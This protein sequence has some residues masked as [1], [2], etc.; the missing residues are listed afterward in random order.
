MFWSLY[1]LILVACAPPRARSVSGSPATIRDLSFW[2]ATAAKRR[3]SAWAVRMSG[4]VAATNAFAVRRLPMSDRDKG[5]EILPLRHKLE[6]LK[7]RLGENKP[8]FAPRT[9]A[10]LAVLLQSRLE[11]R[12]AN[13]GCSCTQTR[14]CDGAAT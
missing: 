13:Y 7:R 10:P 5:T 3:D 11:R 12:Y 14:W 2:T 6:N 4:A 8:R 9:A 1:T